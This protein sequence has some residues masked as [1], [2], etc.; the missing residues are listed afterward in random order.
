[1]LCLL[2]AALEVFFPS[3]RFARL[4]LWVV[5]VKIGSQTSTELQNGMVYRGP[6]LRN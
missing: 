1:M 2:V 4:L 5:D 6:L 3:I